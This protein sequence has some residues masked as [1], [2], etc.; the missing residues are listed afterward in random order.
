MS[1]RAKSRNPQLSPRALHSATAFVSLAFAVSGPARAAI[2]YWSGDQSSGGS[3]NTPISGTWAASTANWYQDAAGTMT[4]GAGVSPA[5]S[6]ATFAEFG[7]TSGSTS[8]TVSANSA[9]TLNNITL[10]DAASVTDTINFT[11]GSSNKLA[12]ASGASGPTLTQDGS[13]N[14]DITDTG[15]AT[16][17]IR[18]S[19]S[20]TINGTGSG[21]ITIS[22]PL[23]NNGGTE[24]L[25][26]NETGGATIAFTP[27][28][29]NFGSSGKLFTIQAGTVDFQNNEA[30]GNSVEG[31][32]LAGGA[33]ESTTGNTM[34][35]YTGGIALGT[36][37]TFTGPVNWGLGSSAVSLA[38][39]SNITVNTGGT[40]GTT[41]AGA[42]TGA[43]GLTLVSGST[44]AL[45]LTNSGDA[46][47]GPTTINGGTLFANGK[48]TASAVTVNSPGILAGDGALGGAVVDGG[49]I[50]PGATSGT[51]GT[52]SF[53]AGLT[54]SGS[55]AAF[56]DNID[57]AGQS[58]ELAVTGN[59]ALGTG[60]TLNVSVLDSTSG[61]P[62]TIATYSGTLTGTFAAANLPAGY[63]VNYGTG[64][65]S[66][67]TLVE[68]PE[69]ASLGLVGI[70]VFGLLKRRRSRR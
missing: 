49:L 16:A 55:S 24:N 8:Y 35:T 44:G 68:V 25:T 43:G 33:L 12:F 51:I 9:I 29:S 20:F 57:M 11:F 22:A 40:S 56:D 30:L 69:P 61:S 45:T 27:N 17:P 59:L 64:S 19:N 50:A 3:V 60:T 14:W 37:F 28:N 62:Y 63:S 23:A 5:S 34:I 32:S 7:G 2:Y 38:A 31:I 26:V 54:F 15:G 67:I 52:L 46:F 48:I 10:D 6:T 21:N 4:W 1:D 41:I 47:A 39:T 58:G 70:S 36:A 13:A 65:D 53:L 66:A 42:I 18:F